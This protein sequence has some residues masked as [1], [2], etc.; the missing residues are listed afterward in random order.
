MSDGSL[1]FVL[2]LQ[3]SPLQAQIEVID[4]ILRKPGDRDIAVPFVHVRA[5]GRNLAIVSVHP[6]HAM[7]L[8]APQ[9]QNMREIL[10]YCTPRGVE[11]QLQQL[12][13]RVEGEPLPALI[14]PLSGSDVREWKEATGETY[15]QRSRPCFE[16]LCRIAVC[17]WRQPLWQPKRFAMNNL[18]TSPLKRRIYEDVEWANALLWGAGE[19]YWEINGTS[20]G[21]P[22]GCDIVGA[23]MREL[24]S[25][26]SKAGPGVL[27]EVVGRIEVGTGLAFLSTPLRESVE[28]DCREA[29]EAAGVGSSKSVLVMCGSIV[30]AILYD[31]LRGDPAKARG[32][33]TV[34]AGLHS[35]PNVRGKLTQAASKDLD[36]WGAYE[37]I[38]VS[39]ELGVVGDD[40]AVYANVL[41]DYRNLIHPA[42]EVRS[43]KTADQYTAAVAI[44]VVNMV[45]RDVTP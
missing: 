42:R 13:N 22:T 25:L 5:E 33:A 37:L 26:L 18:R 15:E 9:A 39:K 29:N 30:E 34:L 3:G 31:S 7:D 14:V 32:T 38:L 8:P 17:L 45:I 40:A 28:R 43:G 41:R 27:P 11:L 35:D 10:L 24:E 6:L 44:Q 19:G 12:V 4:D 16:D 36:T 1:D 2:D 21:I 20:D 23:S